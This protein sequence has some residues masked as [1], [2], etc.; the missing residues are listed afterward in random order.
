MAS[1]HS[2]ALRYVTDMVLVE[3]VLAFLLC[4]VSILCGA[5]RLPTSIICLIVA[6]VL[7]HLALHK[8]GVS[9]RMLPTSKDALSSQYSDVQLT[10]FSRHN[11]AVAALT[12][13][14]TFMVVGLLILV[15]NAVIQK[16]TYGI[17][18]LGNVFQK[19][20]SV[21]IVLFLGI[22]MGAR[23]WTLDAAGGGAAAQGGVTEAQAAGAGAGAQGGATAAQGGAAQAAGAPPPPVTYMYRPARAEPW[24]F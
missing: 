23:V 21:M 8:Y 13:A 1:D 3:M 22:A 4:S 14:S 11:V 20:V 6:Y 24:A 19:T 10:S 2:G 9:S 5:T 17:L 18:Q 7:V 12:L 15:A 16:G